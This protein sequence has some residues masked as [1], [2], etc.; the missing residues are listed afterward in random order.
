MQV[1]ASLL[2]SFIVATP[3]VW[4]A[5]ITKKQLQAAGGNDTDVVAGSAKKMEVSRGLCPRW[6]PT[7]GREGGSVPSLVIV[8]IASANDL[9]WSHFEMDT[10]DPYVEFWMGAE[11]TRQ[12]WAGNKLLAGHHP[13]QY[14]RAETRSLTDNTHPSWEWSCLL[15]YDAG[16]NTTFT[17]KMWD[18]NSLTRDELIGQGSAD[19]HDILKNE[20]SR[21]HGEVEVKLGLKDSEWKPLYHGDKRAVLNVRFEVVREKPKYAVNRV[22]GNVGHQVN[23]IY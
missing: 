5:R 17:A 12:T 15:A 8:T 22:E 11:G 2:F 3:Q 21:G 13:E 9:P 16:G 19:F 10:V 18:H 23:H 1:F 14:W 6:K 20:D 7:L 4:C